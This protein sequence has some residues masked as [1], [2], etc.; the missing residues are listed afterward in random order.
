LRSFAVEGKLALITGATRGIRLAIAHALGSCGPNLIL[1]GRDEDEL[2]H[3]AEDLRHTVPHVYVSPFDLSRSSEIAGWFE[4][5]CGRVGT[6]D[7]LVNSAGISRRGAAVDLSL[8]DWNDVMA[9]N[10]MA[11]LQ[12]QFSAT[13]LRTII[14]LDL[15]IQHFKVPRSMRRVEL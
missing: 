7:I 5:L 11:R 4:D 3:V 12:D 10:T 1:V 15:L 8:E 13:A 14:H 2:E 9:L 6:P